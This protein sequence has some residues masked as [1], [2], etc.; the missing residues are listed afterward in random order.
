MRGMKL[1]IMKKVFMYVIMLIFTLTFVTKVN[2]DCINYTKEEYD[3]LVKNTSSDDLDLS[4]SNGTL[5]TD[6]Y[7]ERV[8]EHIKSLKDMSSSKIIM[9]RYYNYKLNVP[10]YKQLQSN[11][12]GPANIQ[13]VVKYLENVE[14]DQGAIADEMYTDQNGSAYVIYMR[15]A[16]NKYTSKTYEHTLG[17]NYT[18]DT[19]STLVSNNI[20][21][22]KPLILHAKTRTLAAYAGNDLGHYITVNGYTLTA[23]ISGTGIDYMYYVDPF[24]KIYNGVNMLGE[25]RDTASN[26]YGTI[27][28]STR[29]VIH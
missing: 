5:F 3:Y 17:N 19:F 8:N 22:N 25:H 2:A 10:T 28:Y 27:N 18:L 15:N 14:L 9:P 6:E 24:D 12:C 29:Y 20:A 16:L 7:L 23:A 11:Y 21:N 4:C 1:K 13:Q 26:V